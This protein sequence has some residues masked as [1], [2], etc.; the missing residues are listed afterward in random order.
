MTIEQPLTRKHRIILLAV[1]IT[2]G[3]PS[4]AIFIHGTSWYAAIGLFG[5]LWSHNISQIKSL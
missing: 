4:L 3:L 1:S 5:L 2:I